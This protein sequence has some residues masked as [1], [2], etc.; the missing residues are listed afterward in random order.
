MV[1]AAIGLY[2]HNQ[3]NDEKEDDRPQTAV[4]KEIQPA[5]IQ[6]KKSLAQKPMVTTSK[7]VVLTPPV[8]RP[9]KKNKYPNLDDSFAPFDSDGHRVITQIVVVGKHL[10]FHGDLLLGETKDLEKI[11][12]KKSLRVRKPSLWTGGKVPFTIDED[13]E[14]PERIFE[15]VQFI[16]ENTNVQWVERSNEK[17]YIVFRAGEQNCYSYVGRIGGRQPIYLSSSCQVRSILHEMLHTLGFFHEQNREDR[18]QYVQ[19]FWDNIPEVHHAQFKKMPNDFMQLVNRPFDYDSIMLY[20]SG[21]FS[22][23]PGEPSL[24]RTDGEILA[25]VSDRPSPEDLRRVNILYPT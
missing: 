25:P 18:D 22:D 5:K 15:A 1:A 4:T 16:N 23:I 19:V 24:L 8:S 7:K 20:P 10:T 17:D 12:Q 9:G 13:I 21:A 14:F 6:K 2:I 11:K 3:K